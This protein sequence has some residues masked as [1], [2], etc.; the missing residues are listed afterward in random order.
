MKYLIVVLVVVVVGWLLLRGRTSE[1][2]ARRSAARRQRNPQAMVQCA[3]CGVHLP[4]GDAV[5]GSA[6]ARF[7]PRPIGWPGRA[8]PDS[9]GAAAAAPCACAR[10]RVHGA[11]PDF[12]D[13]ARRLRR[14]TAAAPNVEFAARG[15]LIAADRGLPGLLRRACRVKASAGI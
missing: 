11:V 1:R 13:R 2:R 5:R 15:S 12:G 9:P 6:V 7:V 10:T 3:H 14:A 4:R 8:R